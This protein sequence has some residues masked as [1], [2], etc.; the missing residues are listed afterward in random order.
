M[1][2]VRH[3]ARLLIAVFLVTFVVGCTTTSPYRQPADNPRIIYSSLVYDKET[4]TPVRYDDEFSI[5][6]IPFPARSANLT[7][8]LQPKGPVYLT[9]EQVA[10]ID[11]LLLNDMPV[12]VY[13]GSFKSFFNNR[14]KDELYFADLFKKEVAGEV[15]LFRVESTTDICLR[16]LKIWILEK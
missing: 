11:E 8:N 14:K 10:A 4:V 3:F 13:A 7:L 9:K 1:R 6:L 2:Y 5:P 16:C 12:A 15:R